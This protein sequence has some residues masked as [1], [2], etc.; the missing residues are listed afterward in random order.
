M[1]QRVAGLNTSLMLGVGLCSL[2]RL[3]SCFTCVCHCF[4]HA[5][6]SPVFASR[7]RKALATGVFEVAE[8]IKAYHS[9]R[10]TW[11]GFVLDMKTELYILV[12]TADE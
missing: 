7:Y 2:L 9:I 12:N 6:A 5:S 3:C 11:T 8:E 10:P 1:T 4:A